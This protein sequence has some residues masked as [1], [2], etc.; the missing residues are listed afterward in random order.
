MK[1]GV[2]FTIVL[3]VGLLG[4]AGM[5]AAS[6]ADSLVAAWLFDE[7][8]GANVKDSSGLGHD[9]V[10]RNPK[11]ARGK[12]GFA[13]DIVPG[14]G[15]YI[16]VES[17]PALSPTTEMTITAWI[18]LNRLT[19]TDE[20][21]TSWPADGCQLFNSRIIQAGTYDP[22]RLQWGIEDDHYRFLFEYGS[23]IFQVGPSADPNSV[24]V[25]MADMMRAGEWIH[26]AGVYTG[27]RIELY[28]DGELVISEPSS[29]NLIQP[30]NNRLFIGTKSPQAPAGDTWN[31]RLDEV[32]IFNKALNADEIKQVMGGI[33]RL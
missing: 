15:S 3:A 16:E 31:G 28:V 5:A 7:G 30:E 18:Y 12:Y 17:T 2:L 26:I 33:G 10:F 21:C 13:A 22:D 20:V 25:P 23:F 1:R 19:G 11:W 9:G 8:I 24:R 32:A 27:D 4:A 6:P 14:E 29:G